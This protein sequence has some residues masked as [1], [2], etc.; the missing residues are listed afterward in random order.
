[1]MRY[2]V[3]WEQVRAA[4]TTG[5]GVVLTAILLS[6][7]TGCAHGPG[8]T[9]DPAPYVQPCNPYRA[10]AAYDP[11]FGQNGGLLGALGK[12]LMAIDSAGCR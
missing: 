12:T 1:M 5:F 7:L 4:G 3:R 10:Q 8:A 9:Q 11:A 6:S 2:Y